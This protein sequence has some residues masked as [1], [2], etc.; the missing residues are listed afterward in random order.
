MPADGG[1]V[2]QVSKQGLAF[3]AVSKR[4]CEMN[5][6]T[7]PALDK[8]ARWG[9]GPAA[10]RSRATSRTM[11]IA[12]TGGSRLHRQ[13][14][15][16]VALRH[17]ARSGGASTTSAEGHRAAV[18]P[19]ARPS[20]SLRPCGH[21]SHDLDPQAGSGAEAVIHYAANSLG[22][23]VDAGPRESITGT[24]WAV[25]LSLLEAMVAAGVPKIVFSSTC[26]T[27]GLP[28]KVP[29]DE[30]TP[31]R[32]G[33]S[34]RALQADDRGDAALVRGSAWTRN[35]DVPLLQCLRGVGE[36]REHH[37]IETHLIPNVLFAGKGSGTRSIFSVP[38]TRRRTGPRSATTCT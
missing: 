27:Y 14:V 5:G 37:R 9:N 16:G 1:R 26:A 29:I 19:R 2:F 7:C 6:R 23:G 34:L 36:V 11:K 3:Q 38:T 12:V 13:R 4:N 20:R 22:G 35:G 8:G 17:G 31:Q 32:S 33:E 25:G 10:S 24:T 18:D 21:R 15:R 30:S 28:E